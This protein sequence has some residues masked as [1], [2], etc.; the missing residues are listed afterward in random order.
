MLS[1]SLCLSSLEFQLHHSIFKSDV[2][3]HIY[4]SSFHEKETAFELKT[5]P[6][7]IISENIELGGKI[8]IEIRHLYMFNT[9]I[10]T[11]QNE[12]SLL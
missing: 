9:W 6:L 4:I 7:N 8:E 5:I 2:L 12:C 3:E 10:E 1:L 11:D